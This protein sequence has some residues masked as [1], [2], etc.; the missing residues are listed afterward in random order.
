MRTDLPQEGNKFGDYVVID[1]TIQVTKSDTHTKYHVRCKCGKE[2]YVR[3]YFLRIGRQT[4]CKSCRSRLNYAKAKQQG[5]KVGFIK[6]EHQGVGD[7]SKTFYSYIKRNANLRGILWGEN[8]SIEF[9]WNLYL[10]QNKLC[11]LSGVPIGFSSKIINSSVDWKNTTASLDRID[12]QLGY[13]VDNVQ[14]VHKDVNLMKNNLTQ[15]RFIELC[16]LISNK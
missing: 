8:V 16:R 5:K 6:L 4:C 3:G 13:T 7:I 14:W 10:Q 1:D 9:L 2:E 15:L 11:A 12:S